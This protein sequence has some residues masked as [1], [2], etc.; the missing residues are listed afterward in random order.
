MNAHWTENAELLEQF[1]L[2][3]LSDEERTGFERHL[4]ECARCREAV[5]RE[6]ALVVGIRA[7]GRD[8]L[9]ARLRA[10][11]SDD[12][13][14]AS[15]SKP[16]RAGWYQVLAAAA[17]LALVV[18]LGVY[19]RWFVPKGKSGIL[20]S[21]DERVQSPPES[22]G[23]PAS[24][25][26]PNANGVAKSEQSGGETRKDEMKIE[27]SSGDREGAAGENIPAASSLSKRSEAN[28]LSAGEKPKMAFDLK[29]HEGG[30]N[31]G[32]WVE[33]IALSPSNPEEVSES[34]GVVRDQAQMTKKMQLQQK[35]AGAQSAGPS[36]AAKQQS[37]LSTLQSQ[38]VRIQVDQRP[39]GALPPEVQS[40]T[41]A[42]HGNIVISRIESTPAGLRIT[43]YLDRLYTAEEIRQAS[44]QAVAPDSVVVTLPGKRIVYKIPPPLQL[45]MNP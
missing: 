34:K 23:K 16:D 9:K 24:P 36:A 21:E 12:K 13:K 8:G 15:G 44:C 35:S 27:I 11:L 19:N 5:E 26:E 3:Q 29:E 14:D 32:V 7:F 10:K 38:G 1:V 6:T 25:P 18:G 31:A 39:W 41:R 20:F 43:M 4:Q 17:V 42:D 22:V 33:G 40:S 37:G 28:P 45:P 30:E 2:R